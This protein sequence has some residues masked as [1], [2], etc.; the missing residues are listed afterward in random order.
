M[1]LWCESSFG[2]EEDLCKLHSRVH[3]LL[4][5]FSLGQIHPPVTFVIVPPTDR[6]P[7]VEIPG[8]ISGL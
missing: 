2:E 6:T 4:L 7:S 3:S 5:E 1:D 8:S